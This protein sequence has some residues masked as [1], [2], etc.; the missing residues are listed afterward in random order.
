MQPS[1]GA[2]H[3]GLPRRKVLPGDFGYKKATKYD[4]TELRKEVFGDTV[5]NDLPSSGPGG[6]SVGDTREHDVRAYV[7]QSD[8]F[9][10][11]STP[12]L[13][14][15]LDPEPQPFVSKLTSEAPV[16][17]KPPPVMPKIVEQKIDEQ[18]RSYGTGRRKSSTARAWIRP[19]D[20][21][22]RVNGRP[23]FEYFS[24][25]M[26]RDVI[27]KPFVVTELISRFDVDLVVR[28]GGINGQADASRLA[29]AR[30]L[31]AYNPDL[32]PALRH[33]GMLT[34]DA[35]RVERKKIGKKKARRSPQWSKR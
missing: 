29:V 23:V 32:R 4:W 15:V 22:V 20:G 27:V 18:G 34:R 33:S 10:E 30:A 7:P 25:F 16:V 35:R 5:V 12:E 3:V 1:E 2:R 11:L 21:V 9:P 14:T 6:T 17:Q 19:G 8:G 28:G 31:Q 24:L 13:D 26:H